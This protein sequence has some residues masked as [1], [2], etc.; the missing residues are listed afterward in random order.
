M[1]VNT[2]L[3][4]KYNEALQRTWQ[5]PLPPGNVSSSSNCGGGKALIKMSINIAGIT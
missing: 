1:A 5:L 3:G 2:G 4:R